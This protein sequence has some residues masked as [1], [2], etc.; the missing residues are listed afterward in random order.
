MISSNSLPA[1]GPQGRREAEWPR[2]RKRDGRRRRP[3]EGTGVQ[4]GQEDPPAP[5]S[6]FCAHAGSVHRAHDC[7]HMQSY[8]Q[9]T[10][11]TH[12]GT[13]TRVHSH[14]CAH[15]H[16]HVH[17]H[18]QCTRH[19]HMCVH[20]DTHVSAHAHTCM[21]TPPCPHGLATPCRTLPECHTVRDPRSHRSPGQSCTS[22]A[23]SV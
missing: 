12:V 7:S 9:N 19:K 6:L 15:V 1:T 23:P 16:M 3:S 2:L 14:T 11:G 22:D 8:I 18:E 17:T 21:L 4:G 20:R 13:C 10:Q 5:L